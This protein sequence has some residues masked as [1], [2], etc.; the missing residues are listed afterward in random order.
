MEKNAGHARKI[1]KLAD[2]YPPTWDDPMIPRSLRAER[3]GLLWRGQLDT[4]RG[5]SARHD[6]DLVAQHM[7]TCRIRIAGKME[8]K[9]PYLPSGKLA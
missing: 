6:P 5:I 4:S 9:A 8:R 1:S 7:G 3:Q 2:F